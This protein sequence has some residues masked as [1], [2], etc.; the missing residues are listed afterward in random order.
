VNEDDSSM[1]DDAVEAVTG[2]R[3]VS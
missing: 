3:V 2:E 1:L